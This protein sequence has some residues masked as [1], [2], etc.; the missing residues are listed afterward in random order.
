MFVGLQGSGKTTTCNKLAYYYK[1]KGFKVCMVCADT[2]RA[3][4]FD[5]LKQNATKSKIPLYGSYTETDPATVA[6]GGV[7]KFKE[8]E[9]EIIIVDT[10]GRHKQEEALFEEMEEVAAAVSP[11]DIIFVMDSSIG[12]AAHDQALAFRQSV[13]VGS[14]I[15][16]KMDGHASGG[17]ALSAV[18]AT[19][20]PVVFIGTGEHVDDFEPFDAQ[21]FVQRLLG[22]GDIAGLVDA[23]KD[24]GFDQ[25]EELFSRLTQGLFTLRDMYEY[26]ANIQ[27]MGPIDKVMSMMP[28][29][30]ADLLPK[31]SARESQNV[32]NKFMCIMDSMTGEELDR[33]KLFNNNSKRVLRVARGSGTSVKMVSE[34]LKNFK[35]FEKDMSKMSG[36][37][38]PQMLQ[39]VGGPQGFQQMMRKMQN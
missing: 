13:E 18:A 5:Q 27:K 19:E 28:G 38:T 32:I 12:Q 35:R 34:L 17:G 37:F 24:A 30:S 10:S 1:R 8:E 25:N 4:A 15:I 33:P 29:F 23:V 9:Y 3:G 14:V 26:F 20:S 11:D 6:G 31:G 22:M 21:S 7:R 39:Q 36:M 16:T 2:F